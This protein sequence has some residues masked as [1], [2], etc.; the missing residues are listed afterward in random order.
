[1]ISLPLLGMIAL[2]QQGT[3]QGATTPP[4]GDTL[5]YWQQHVAYTIVATLDEEQTK[6][7]ATGVL[8]YTNN[9]PDTLREMYF[10]QYLNAFRPGSKWSAVDEHEN[11]VRFQNLPDPEYGYERL[12]EAPTVDGAPVLVDYPGAPDSTVMHLRL[13]RPLAPHDSVQIRFSWDA[14]PSTVARRQGRSGRSYDFAQW[15]P[16]VAVYDRGGWEQNALIPAGELYGEYGTYDVTMQVRDDQVIAS[17]GVPV[18]GDPGWAR[19]SRTGPPHLEASAYADVPGPATTPPSGY[20]SV[21]FRAENVHHFAWSASPDY[22]YEGGLYVRRAPPTHFQT[23]DTVAV[24]VLYKAGDDSTWGGGRAVE[25]SIVALKW[26]ESIWGPYAYPQFTNVHRI[27]AGGTEF[28]MM[29]MDGSA[30]QGLILHEGGHIFTY[31]ILG[32]NEWRSGWMDEGLTSYQTDWAQKLTP[33]ELVGQVLPPPR[34]ADGYRVNGVRIPA[35]DSMYLPETQLELIGRAQ[36]IGTNSADFTEFGIYNGTIYNRAKLM[37]GQ[38]RDVMGDTAFTAFFHDYYDRWALKHVDERAMRVSAERAYGHALGWFFDEWVHGTGLMDY[39]LGPAAVQTDGSRYETIVRVDRR[40]AMR[41]PISVGVLTASGWTLGH[42]DPLVDQQY[43]HVFTP[44]QPQRIVL[45]PYHVTWDWDRR[46]DEASGMLFGVRKPR[47][48]FNWPYLDQSDRAHTVVALAPAV[49]YSDPQGVALGIRA[50]SNYLSIVDKYDAGVAFTTRNAAG[51]NGTQSSLGARVQLWAR[52]ENLYL[53][54]MDRPL[55][56]VGGGINYLDGIAKVDLFKKWDLSPFILTPSPTINVKAYATI[57]LPGDSLLLP[58]QW[59]NRNVGEVG[60]SGLYKTIPTGGGEY[61]IVRASAALGLASSGGPDS[62]ERA[63]GY[64]RAEGSAGAVRSLVGSEAQLHVRLYGGVA[65][66]APRERAIFAS[67][68]DP[69]ETFDND[70]FRPRGAALKR[71][72]INYLPL[73]GAGLRGFG[74]NVPLDGVLAVNGEVVQRL[75][76]LRGKWGSGTLSASLFGD[77]A[78]ASSK[79]LVLPDALLSDAGAGLIARGRVYDRNLYV[80]LD[81]PVFVNHPSLAGGRGLGGNGSFAP[82][83]TITVGDLW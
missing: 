73:G 68:Q 39:A 21:R 27:D 32:N 48:A 30:S 55:M 1:M 58:E 80:R 12:T 31:G 9:S 3:Y 49:W 81:A 38:L 24:H 15:Y 29:I 79:Q 50:R 19:V 70:L 13:P 26:L 34:L 61:E 63:G 62:D 66:N 74:F 76:A 23:W 57:A 67:S 54:G 45:D 7:R 37:Y 28:P 65:H 41:H 72:G 75:T 8:V 51:P 71:E 33:Q 20:R 22:R 64:L 82:R 42:G 77:A 16:K 11:R 17:T 14:R 36:P 6:L 18:S 46:N 78:F 59:S 2:L 52:G 10:H 44:T 5:G 56:G 53:P 25:R 60:G 40:G 47:V 4:S 69:F 35:V 43:V 83:W